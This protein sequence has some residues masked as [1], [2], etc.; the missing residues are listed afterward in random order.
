[1][2]R[3][4]RNTRSKKKAPTPVRGHFTISEIG[5]RGDGLAKDGG[6]TVFIPHVL[7]GEEIEANVIGDR[8]TLVAI[9]NPSKDRIDPPCPHYEKCGGCN[10]QHMTVP[11]YLS[12]KQA[13][14]R[15]ALTAQNI[16]IDPHEI[17]PIAPKTRR[18]ASFSAARKG[19]AFMFGFQGSKSHLIEEI[20]Q[21]L[22]L[23]PAI[24][25]KLDHLRE[26]AAIICPKK[27]TLKMH[28]F[29]SDG[30]LDIRLDEFGD[31]PD[32]GTER[33][34]VEMAAKAGF[35]RVS[36]GDTV[37]VERQAVTVHFGTAI[38]TLAPGAFTQATTASE[39]TLVSLVSEHTKGFT[40]LLDLFA[41]SG[42]FAL[43]LARQSRVHAV[44][45]D[46][47]AINTLDKAARATPSL[48]PVTSEQRD[49][50]RRPLMAKELNRFDAIVLDP[51]RAG[52]KEQCA[53][54]AKATI[55]T[56][57]YVSCS[58]TSF[59]RD[60]RIL[61]DG[62]YELNHVFAVDQF[63]FSHHIELVGVF[64]KGKVR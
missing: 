46:K 25:S 38:A 53:E 32:F 54:L 49:L 15:K 62:G 8:G 50:F 63:L 47:A 61:I 30:G 40:H 19:G 29:S 11:S 48:K 41:G 27:G 20:T 7:E 16:E 3:G 6:R 64:T 23:V 43:N 36:L 34:L 5:S 37:L 42:T 24:E 26:T 57:V 33:A 22:I 59:A 56:L 9:R 28:V 35:A 13:Q 52:A 51:P 45:G 14:V 21:C 1:M 39:N 12:W 55:D 58:P 10:L 60:A 2:T 18:R 31:W 17:V 4:R 44:E